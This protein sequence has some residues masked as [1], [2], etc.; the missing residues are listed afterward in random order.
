MADPDKK[1]L[2][3]EIVIDANRKYPL[4][5]GDMLRFDEAQIDEHLTK[6]PSLYAWIATLQALA[7]AKRKRLE[8]DL[9]IAEEQFGQDLR[10]AAAKSGVKLT[11]NGIKE[12]KITNKRLLDYR[13]QLIETEQQEDICKGAAEAF[14]Q[15]KDC[16]VTFAA[17]LR[18]QSAPDP[19]ISK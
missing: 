17:N 11:E 10:D 19:S 13:K 8:L 18:A 3:V 15:R 1:L 5:L 4:D 7:S 9:E 14:R 12:Q 2:Q 16:L 6:Q